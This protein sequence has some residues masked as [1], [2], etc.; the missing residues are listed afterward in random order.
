VRKHAFA[1]AALAGAAV[2]GCRSPDEPA[3][4]LTMGT[5]MRLLHASAAA[6]PFDVIVDNIVRLHDVRYAGTSAYFPVDS[7]RRQLTFRVSGSTTTVFTSP[8]F[9]E[10]NTPYTLMPVSASNL[11]G[12]LFVPDTGA[13]PVPDK[14]KL[15]VINAS[16]TAPPID[17][18]LRDPDTPNEFVMYYP[19]PFASLSGWRTATPGTWRVR[20]RSRSDS[21][22]VADTGPLTLTAGRTHT[23]V[24][25]DRPGGGV[26][27]ALLPDAQ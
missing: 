13:E 23:L 5:R 18:L 9:F 19:S 14:S 24:L 12:A 17:V 6:I 20:F 16:I 26:A 4:P 27:L 22:V 2:V 3:A 7:G 10:P 1:L 15:R 25:M 8:A 11:I 21:T